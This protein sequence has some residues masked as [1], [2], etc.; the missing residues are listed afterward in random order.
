MSPAR[1]AVAA[2]LAVSVL[3]KAGGMPVS[4]LRAMRDLSLPSALMSPVVAWAHLA[5]Q[6]SIAVTLVI[7]PLAQFAAVAACALACLYLVV[8]VSRRGRPCR[9]VVETPTVIGWPTIIRNVAFVGLTV[10]AALAWRGTVA[11]G[12]AAV[13]TVGFVA[14]ELVERHLTEPV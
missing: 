1:I 10:C 3:S 4:M 7:P 5:V 11:V 2:I 12:A 14:L 9:C 6:A 13:L 8:V